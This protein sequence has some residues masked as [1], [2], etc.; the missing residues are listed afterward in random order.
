[1]W[2]QQPL[3]SEIPLLQRAHAPPPRPASWPRQSSSHRDAHSSDASV[4]SGSPMPPSAQHRAL[5]HDV[6]PQ[7]R[8]SAQASC[9]PAAMSTGAG[10]LCPRR[11][12]SARG[13]A[14]R[15]RLRSR[16]SDDVTG[17]VLGTRPVRPCRRAR[18]QELG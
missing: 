1:M 14:G 17:V 18:R 9:E 2:A 10:E 7:P 16:W 6:I 5:L 3:V 15:G 12:D 11:R 4:R 13:A 8:A